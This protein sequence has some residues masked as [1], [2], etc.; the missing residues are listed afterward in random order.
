MSAVLA[1]N[2]NEA[3]GVNAAS[4]KAL[5]VTLDEAW[6]PARFR[7]H[8]AKGLEVPGDHL[9]ES[10]LFWP[11][12]FVVIGMSE[13]REG[14]YEPEVTIRRI[15]PRKALGNQPLRRRDRVDDRR[16]TGARSPPWPS[17]A[18][19]GAGREPW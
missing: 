3:V 12:L 17:T 7:C 19:R 6:K 13:H 14:S 4:E 11:S 2:A 18:P 10:G 16:A 15:P 9:V 8:L 5:E 1:T